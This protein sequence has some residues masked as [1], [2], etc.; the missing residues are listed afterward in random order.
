M[1]ENG[2][3]SIAT[4]EQ[5]RLEFPLAGLGSRFL[6][7]LF[8]TTLS[9]LALIL[10][11]FLG[12]EMQWLRFLHGQRAWIVAAEILTSFLIVWGYF[13]FFEIYWHGQTPGK[14]LLHVRVLDQHGRAATPVQILTRNLVRAADFFPGIYG[15]GVICMLSNSQARRLGDWAA[16]TVVV[17]ESE[18]KLPECNP[19][20]LPPPGNAAAI[21]LA[22][23]QLSAADRQLVERFLSRRSDLNFTVKYAL[24]DKIAQ[25]LC[26]NPE[27]AASRPDWEDPEAWLEAIAHAARMGTGVS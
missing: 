9:T 3:Y 20:P 21:Q 24:A 2:N 16:G 15:V 19:A 8:D 14:R 13:S 22:A 11:Y 1:S 4:P 25:Q 7:L 27:I 5:I 23:R 6:A 10:F 12:S 17:H 18:R 26:Q